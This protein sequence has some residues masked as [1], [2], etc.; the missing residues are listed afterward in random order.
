MITKVC[1]FILLFV[2]LIAFDPRLNAQRIPVLNQIDL[3]HN[4]YFHELYLPQLTSGSSS[5]AWMPDSKSVVY[6]MAGSLWKQKLGS[7]T[8]EQ[9]TDADGYDYQPDVSPDGKSIVFVRY[10]GSSME[11]MLLE[12]KSGET[13]SLTVNKAVNLEPRWSPDGNKLAFVSTANTGHFLLYI[14]NV[15]TDKLS[16]IRCLT[17]DNK[18][19]V[20]RYYYSAFDHAINPVWSK[21]GDQL[22]FISNKEIAHGTGDIVSMN[23]DDGS[24]KI[25][26]HEETSWRTKPDISP[27][28]SRLVYSSYL[29]RNWQQLWLIPLEGDYPIPLTYGEY[30]NTSPRWSPTSDKIAFISNRTGNTALWIVNAFDGAQQQLT[31][32][33]L[34]Y[35]KAR[36]TLSFSVRDE[37]EIPIAARVS[38]TDSRGKFYSP[39]NSWIHA[40]DSRYPDHNQ[41]EAH[42]FHSKGNE[43]ISLPKD[44]F[45]IQ[46]S[47]GPEFEIVKMEI[48]TRQ[49]ISSPLAITLKKLQVPSNFGNWLSGDLHVHMNYGGNYRNTPEILVAQAEAENLNFVFNLI[50]NKEQ[51]I[52]DINYFTPLPDKHSTN[53][54]MILHAQEFHTS[55]WGHL[56]LLNLNNNVILP[57][58]SGYPKTA[59]E[60]LF[61]HNGFIADKAHE[62]QGLVGYVHPF[63]TSQIFPEQSSTLFSEL[64]VDVALGKVNYYELVGFADHKASEA[65]WYQLL[66]CGFR[67]PAGAGTDAMANYSSLR[68]PVG[69][70]RVYV[71]GEGKLDHK[72]FLQKVM[73]GKSF[74]TN[75]PLLGLA[76]DGKTAGDSITISTRGQTLAYTAFLRS[77]IPVDYLEIIWNGEVISKHK[78]SGPTKSADVK[79]TITVKASGWILLR[80][81]SEKSD[82]DLPDLYPYASTNPI[83]IVSET[84]NINQKKAADYFLKWVTRL[85]SKAN[86]LPYR[87]ESE[88]ETV[89]QDI[90][91]AKDFYQQRV[92]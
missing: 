65:V 88:K 41:Y 92:K 59:V 60:S 13:K 31:I 29:G 40:D 77:Q 8:A 17:P 20:N 91:N 28:G 43:I 76:V 21:N 84:K 2:L 47:R 81:W 35:L 9:L 7:D 1:Q 83:Y 63:E 46:V 56:G 34:H 38:I 11:L 16:D 89:M 82:P 67:L 4:Y 15:E 66:N 14:A 62:Q 30:D 75:G 80:A 10:N 44:K 48:D 53:K 12:V 58:Y 3:P 27:D 5:V 85:E 33:D 52:P 36:T 70:N 22:Y 74:V 64:P 90:R 19:N 87:N 61:P 71:K 18:S 39:R 25:I 73:Q 69:L 79:G 37:N 23:L 26:H 45:M 51:R 32:N 24:T 49:N 78:L 86:D 54:T 6:S 42:Y 50:V 72:I 68:G 55:F 57:G